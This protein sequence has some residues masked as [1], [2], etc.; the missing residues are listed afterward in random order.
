[1]LF[2]AFF[3]VFYKQLTRNIGSIKVADDWIRTAGT[4]GV[5]S[6]L[7][8][9]WAT[10]TAP[11]ESYCCCC[12]WW[13]LWCYV[14]DASKSSFAK[15][16][17]DTMRWSSRSFLICDLRHEREF[18]FGIWTDKNDGGGWW[19]W[20]RIWAEKWR[21]IKEMA[22]RDKTAKLFLNFSLTETDIRSSDSERRSLHTPAA[23][24]IKPLWA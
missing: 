11:K 9:N 17:F 14:A 8:A 21:V 22:P 12:R 6:D 15:K 1:M 5:G 19:R 16:N 20:M 3:F 4:I 24:L 23:N 10:T 7:S 2:P 18:E 13:W